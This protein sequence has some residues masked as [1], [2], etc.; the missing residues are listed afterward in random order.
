MSYVLAN[1]SKNINPIR[2]R[3]NNLSS[4]PKTKSNV[5]EKSTTSRVKSQ[6]DYAWTWCQSCRHGGHASHMAVSTLFKKIAIY[7]IDL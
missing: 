4:K 6:F 2:S 3:T 5:Y 1:G 7:D